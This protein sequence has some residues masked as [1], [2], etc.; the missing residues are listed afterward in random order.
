MLVVRT[1]GG[2]AVEHDGAVCEGT[3]ARRK[4]LALLALLAVAGKKGLSRDKL[5][6]YLWPETDALAG[7]HLLKQTCYALRHDLGEPDLFLGRDELRLNPAVASSD[8]QAFEDALESGDRDRAAALYT[9]PFLDGFYLNGA[10]EFERWVGGERARIA[11]RACAALEAVAGE[12]AARGDHT[13]AADLW[14]RLATLDPL[15]A[16]VAVGLMSALDAAGDRAGALQ[17][18]RVHE[19]WLREEFDTAP[20]RSVVELVERLL[21]A[22]DQRLPIPAPPA[23]DGRMDLPPMPSRGHAGASVPGARVRMAAVLALVVGGFFTG[24]WLLFRPRFGARG[25]E[26]ARPSKRLVV[27]PFTNL[28]RPEDAYFA[29]GVTEEITARLG[30]IDR[31]RVIAGTNGSV[32]TDTKKTAREIGREL[33][34]DYVLEGSVRWE[35]ATQGRARVRVT[36]QLVSASDDTHLWAEV[37]EEPLDEIFR[38]QSDVA[39]KVVAALDVTLLERERRLVEAKPTGNLQAYDYYLRGKDYMHRG[40]E[41]RFTRTALRMYEKA[42]ELDPGF[43]LAYAELSQVHS[44]MYWFYYDRSADGR[45]KAKHAVDKAFEL[46]PGLPEGHRALGFYL[47]GTMEYDRALREFNAAAAIRPGDMTIYLLRATIQNRE[48]NVQGAL[49]EFER[50]LQL[51]PGSPIVMDSYAQT[52]DRLRD[53]ARAEPL[54]NRALAVSPDWFSPYFW[55]AGMYLR[56][57]GDTHRARAV[58]DEARS[59]GVA[60]NPLIVFERVLVDVFDRKY[61][62]AL[63][64]LSRGGPEVIQDQFRFI[65]RALL[66]AQIHGLM[67]RHDLERTYYDSARSFVYKKVQDRPDDPRLHSAL[68]IAYAGLGRRLEAIREGQTAVELMPVGKEAYRGYYRGWDLARIYTMVGEYDAAVAQLEQLLSIPGQLTV[69]WL[70]IDPT[71]DPL[72]SHPRFQ[73]LLSEK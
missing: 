37:Y 36:P 41:E 24:G 9:G 2:L 69:R 52:Y 61:D 31:L 47:L 66:C 70:R 63:G 50:A 27:L 57:Y 53:F 59:V 48:G 4:T 14:R 73:K 22:F 5:L 3:A 56:G 16:R 12:A 23:R 19:A 71:W 18:A 64:E 60:D 67:R 15:N 72:R 13:R 58:L 28:G 38:V 68:G 6:G 26:A 29:E 25:A 43:A 44:R 34:A 54:Y 40:T 10:G 65:P 55:K 8:I 1:F 45:A 49:A 20:D 7:R 42:V 30:A 33:G 39:R 11:Q 46:A 51:D 35:K 17:F 32:Y 21:E 62:A